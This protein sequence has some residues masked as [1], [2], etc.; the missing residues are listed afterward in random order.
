MKTFLITWKTNSGF[1]HTPSL[2]RGNSYPEAMKVNFHKDAT[3]A[4]QNYEEVF[5]W[6]MNIKLKSFQYPVP[7]TLYYTQHGKGKIYIKWID[8]MVSED[9]R[10]AVINTSTKNYCFINEVANDIYRQFNKL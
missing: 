6:F 5:P 1:R 7:V 3:N 9:I 10:N 8:G 4:V 2:I